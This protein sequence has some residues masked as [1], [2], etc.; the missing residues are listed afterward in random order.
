MTGILLTSLLILCPVSNAIVTESDG[1]YTVQGE[2]INIYDTADFSPATVEYS[3]IHQCNGVYFYIEGNPVVFDC[4]KNKQLKV[5]HTAINY[6]DSW[7]SSYSAA[8][9][10]ARNFAA[11]FKRDFTT[12]FR[13]SRPKNVNWKLNYTGA[14]P[15]VNRTTY[16]SF[17]S[18]VQ[19]F[20]FE[21]VTFQTGLQHE[22]SSS[23]NNITVGASVKEGSMNDRPYCYPVINLNAKYTWN[24]VTTKLYCSVGSIESLSFRGFQL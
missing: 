16:Y 18:L 10:D 20:N 17:P 8:L 5:Y 4:W 12:T 2:N 7:Y 23:T 6:Q 9:Q 24:V 11:D 21:N 1:I 19:I 14:F 15:L 22:Y 3:G 13:P